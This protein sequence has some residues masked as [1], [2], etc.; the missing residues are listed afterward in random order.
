MTFSALP[1]GKNE[2]AKRRQLSLDQLSN[3]AFKETTKRLLDVAIVQ[4]TCTY[5]RRDS[6]NNHGGYRRCLPGTRP[7]VRFADAS[8]LTGSAWEK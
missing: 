2:G 3:R 1:P 7:A 6:N 8:A 5:S 4:M